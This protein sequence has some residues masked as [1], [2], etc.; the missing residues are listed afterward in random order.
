MK[1][2]VHFQKRYLPLLL[3]STNKYMFLIVRPTLVKITIPGTNFFLK[4]IYPPIIS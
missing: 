2:P 1:K 4:L 3:P